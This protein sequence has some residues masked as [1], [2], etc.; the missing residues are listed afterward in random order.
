MPRL[1]SVERVV[2]VE[3]VGARADARAAPTGATARRTASSARVGESI[4]H[5]GPFRRS[6]APAGPM[7]SSHGDLVSPCDASLSAPRTCL[8]VRGTVP[9][10]PPAADELVASSGSARPRGEPILFVGAER[11]Q[12]RIADHDHSVRRAEAERDIAHR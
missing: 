4:D 2:G 5:L 6:P 9:A 12:D 1:K 10:A 8:A 3:P 7:P 11:T